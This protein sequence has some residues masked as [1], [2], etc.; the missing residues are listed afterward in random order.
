MT[1][2]N[3][4]VCLITSGTFMAVIG[5]SRELQSKLAK[6]H[7]N[8][9]Q[10]YCMHVDI[11]FTC[12][13]QQLRHICKTYGVRASIS[14]ANA[15]DS[16]YRVSINFVLDYCERYVRHN[17]VIC[18]PFVFL[19][20]IMPLVSSCFLSNLSHLIWFPV[21]YQIYPPQLRLMVRMCESS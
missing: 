5:F 4:L 10:S 3:L 2:D 19:I 7:Y 6:W 12:Y 1:L 8:M 17:L 18:S 14:T 13:L 15:R 21:V 11:F 20:Q 9:E 16:I